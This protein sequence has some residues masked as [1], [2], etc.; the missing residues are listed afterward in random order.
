MSNSQQVTV[1][2]P[3]Q[4]A[5][6]GQTGAFP[7]ELFDAKCLAQGDSWFSIGAFPPSFTTN[8]LA[9]MQLAK[10][11]VAVNCARPG[12][13]LQH[14]TDTAS[15]PMFLRLLTG[16]LAY[17]WDAIL[18]SGG[19]NDLIDAASVGPDAPP[20]QR[21][22]LK[23]GE[24]G[25]GALSGD[26]YIGDAGWKTFADHLTVVFNQ[27]LDVRDGGI[28]QGVPLAMHTYAHIMPRPAPAGLG[29]GP[30]L[31]P[32]MQAFAVPPSDQL[33]VSEALIDRLAVLLQTL[34]ADREAAHPNSAL[35]LVDTRTAQ[36][37]LADPA[38]T[39]TSGDFV[40]EIHPTAGGYVKM[41]A[42]WRQTLDTLL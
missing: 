40:N 31:L 32:A 14:M 37:Q 24:R 27:L 39:A 21:L 2:S 23:P 36:L 38:A 13:V 34:M 5:G 18:I 22:L 4:V 16:P 35:H 42:V 10:H 6:S 41:A 28:N 9:E 3:W 15:E 12:K 1:I 25:S 19:G 20:D 8:V 11:V 26:D 30:W 7:F 17:K 29:F 33:A